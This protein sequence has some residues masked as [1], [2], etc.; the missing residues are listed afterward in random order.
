MVK[1][2]LILIALPLLAFGQ[3]TQVG[4]FIGRGGIARLFENSA[5]HVV[6]GVEACFLCGGRL[7]LF[8]EYQHWGKTGTGT[9][10]PIA[11]NLISGGLRIQGK[12]ERVRPF[13]DIG[14]LAGTERDNRAI[15]PFTEATHGIGGGVLGFGVAISVTEHWYVRPMAKIVGLSSTEAGGFAGASIG[16]RF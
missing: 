10:Q 5:Y 2:L 11:M 4:G 9:D 12:G 6:T 14:V 16:Y 8:A 7:G 15:Y 3:N 1:S 13:F